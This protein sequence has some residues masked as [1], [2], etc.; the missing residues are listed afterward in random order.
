MIYGESQKRRKEI[1]GIVFLCTFVFVLVSLISYSPLDPSFNSSTNRET[2]NL[3]G[4][5][6]SYTADACFQTFGLAAF[7]LLIP[8]FLL[9]IH[10]FFP[11]YLERRLKLIS[12]FLFIVFSCGLLSLILKNITLHNHNLLAGGIVGYLLTSFLLPYLNKTGSYIVIL[13]GVFITFTLATNVTITQMF[14]AFTTLLFQPLSILKTFGGFKSKK[15][16]PPITLPPENIP[17][18]TVSDDSPPPS[19]P[20]EEPIIIDD[21]EN[22]TMEEENIEEVSAP[23]ELS[24]ELPSDLDEEPPPIPSRPNFSDTDSSPPIDKPKKKDFF[25]ISKGPL[26]PKG[27]FKL[28]FLHILSDSNREDIHIDRETL[29]KNSQI[30]EQKLKDFNIEGRVVEVRPGPVIT[31]YEFEPAAGIKVSKIVNL[32]DDLSLALSA[33]SVRIIAPIPGKSVVGI[34]LPNDRRQIVTLKEILANNEFK[35]AKYCL[36]LALGKSIGGEPLISDLAKMPHLLVA[37]STGSGKS[38]FLNSIIC[39]FL[40]RYTPNQLRFLLIDPKMLEL[41]VYDN[42]PHLLLPVVTDPKKAALALKWAVEEMDRRYMIMTKLGVRNIDGYNKRI[43]ESSKE[44]LEELLMEGLSE[45]EKG[46]S[47]EKPDALPYV[48]IIIDE[49]A[50][51]MMV[52]SKEVELSIARLAQMARASGI[53]LL[54]ATQRP[55]VDVL[56]GLIK[57]NFPARISFQVSSKIDSRTILDCSGAEKLLGSGDML[58]LPPGTAKVT[59]IHGAYVS[60]SEIK[61][62]VQFL[63]NQGSPQYEE[64]ILEKKFD[65]SDFEFDEEDTALYNEAIDLISKCRYASISMVQRRLRIGYNRAARMI[66]QMEAD[67]I[68]GPADGAKPREV[69][70]RSNE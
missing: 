37:G 41:S 39:T 55:S 29:I 47:F 2:Q 17:V 60:D 30:L 35:S 13:G 11:T 4:L 53:H 34:E 3:A 6:G 19:L 62:L 42:I 43:E 52:A 59:R 16:L 57:A 7:F 10:A 26:K 58:F 69:L 27:N 21:F 48:I 25:K 51:L 61:Q 12:L 24:G 38:V 14:H 36:P 22:E 44:E 68:V 63:K 9:V 15:R 28:P 5:V 67:G 54:V 50:D 20:S 45:E 1:W 31:V 32:A 40:L 64:G 46:V 70:I 65:E 23:V 8:L 49:L 33:L 66:E 18:Q 56:T